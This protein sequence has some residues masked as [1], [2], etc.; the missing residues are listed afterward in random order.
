MGRLAGDLQLPQPVNVPN[1]LQDALN[2]VNQNSAADVDR[3][4]LTQQNMAPS[5]P[6]PKPQDPNKIPFTPPNLGF[7]PATAGG[8]GS[9]GRGGY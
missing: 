8:T 2:L 4:R 9:R 3:G 5:M 6:K 1:N 7:P